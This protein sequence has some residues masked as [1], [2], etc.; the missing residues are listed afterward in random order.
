MD[1]LLIVLAALIM[2]GVVD[3]YDKQKKNS[4]FMWA[5]VFAGVVGFAYLWL[6]LVAMGGA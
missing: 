2:G 4:A 5:L 3:I 6:R 1:W